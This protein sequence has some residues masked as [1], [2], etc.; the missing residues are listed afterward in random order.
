MNLY[1][2]Q[3]NNL[4]FDTINDVMTGLWTPSDPDTVALIARMS[5]DPPL[6]LKALLDKTIIDLKG[7][8]IWEH[9]DSLKLYGLHT[10][11]ASMLNIK[12]DKYNS[13][14]HGIGWQSY[15]GVKG[16]AVVDYKYID[17]G[18]TG[19]TSGD[20]YQINDSF[21]G[22]YVLDNFTASNGFWQDANNFIRPRYWS[23][24]ANYWIL[25]RMNTNADKIIADSNSQ[26]WL[27][28]ER[29][30]STQERVI[31]N[32]TLSV[33]ACVNATMGTVPW[34]EM[35]NGITSYGARVGVVIYGG[36]MSAQNHVDLRTIITYWITNIS[37]L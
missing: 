4:V 16:F 34:T 32:G 5:V 24:G 8:A 35:W 12:Q 22:T 10:E 37:R 7:Y 1:F 20:N 25:A 31:K 15:T 11:Q 18:F 13:T 28:V 33:V 36:G 6:R 29:K 30:N 19:G 9:I 27:I 23:G 26:G 14:N 21:F 3:N 2:D 17:S